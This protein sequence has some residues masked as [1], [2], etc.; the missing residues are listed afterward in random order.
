MRENPLALRQHSL[1]GPQ[2]PR[3]PNRHLTEEPLLGTH[4]TSAPDPHTPVHMASRQVLSSLSNW[5]VP[6]T[7][8]TN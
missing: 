2:L 8:L 4:T 3:G 1:G 5:N 6:V 7:S